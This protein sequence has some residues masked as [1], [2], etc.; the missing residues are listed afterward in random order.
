MELT[1]G[2]NFLLENPSDAPHRRSQ[3]KVYPIWEKELLNK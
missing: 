3:F 2:L 1:L